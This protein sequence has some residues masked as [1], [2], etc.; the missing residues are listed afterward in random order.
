[1]DSERC[2]NTKVLTLLETGQLKFILTLSTLASLCGEV[3]QRTEEDFPIWALSHAGINNGARL[4]PVAAKNRAPPLP[5]NINKKNK[6][7]SDQRISQEDLYT[8]QVNDSVLQLS[9]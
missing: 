2:Y 8:R 5:K 3:Y 4:Q 1:M 9:V 7:P 6:K